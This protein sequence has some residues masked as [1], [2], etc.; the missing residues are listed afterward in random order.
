MPAL[1]VRPVEDSRVLRDPVVPNHDGALLP[2][3]AC[4]EVGAVGQVVVQELEQ[5]VGL[6]AFQ[7]DN[8]AGD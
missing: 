7:A 4:L 6:F 8:V 3:D 1:T 2:L 5:R